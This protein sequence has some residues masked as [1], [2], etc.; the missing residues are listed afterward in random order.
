M[1]QLRYEIA[2]EERK[3]AL[4]DVIVVGR[5]EANDLSLP[6][7]SSA[8][9]RHARFKCE[10]A[11][12]QVEDLGSRNGTFVEREG[13]RHRVS[14]AMLLQAGDVIWIGE[15]R[16]DFDAESAPPES[17]PTLITDIQRTSVPGETVRGQGKLPPLGAEPAEPEPT[18][19]S[20]TELVLLIA[21]AVLA[22]VLIIGLMYF[23]YR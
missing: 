4:T 8:S 22:V 6:E 10:G 23:L 2:G 7:D 11:V 21:A 14:T 13:K 19:R 9:R 5:D 18:S 15:M 1:A 20:R 17:A 3:L 12:V 16:F